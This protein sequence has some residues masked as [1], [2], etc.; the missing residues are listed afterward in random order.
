MYVIFILDPKGQGFARTTMTNIDPR[1]FYT[2]MKIHIMC[3][4][5]T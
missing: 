2:H 5:Y 1:Y 3:D 4:S